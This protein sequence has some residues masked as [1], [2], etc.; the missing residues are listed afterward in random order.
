MQTSANN[1]ILMC[2]RAQWWEGAAGVGSITIFYRSNNPFMCVG[3]DLK[4]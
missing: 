4:S 2:M 3:S 1:G